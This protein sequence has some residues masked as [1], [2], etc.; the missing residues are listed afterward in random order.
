MKTSLQL[1]RRVLA[2]L[3]PHRRDFVLALI[4]MV[5]FGASD[6]AVPFLVKHILDDVFQHQDQTL[7][8]LLPLVL[9]VYAV[10]RALFD[11]GQQYLMARIGHRVIRDMRNGL[12][13]HLLKLEPGFFVRHESADLTARMTSDVVLVRSLLTETA[14]AIIRDSIR[15]V[16]LLVA[17][18]YLD[19]VLAVIAFVFFP[20]GIYPVY[21]FGRRMRKLS[22][23]GQEGIGKLSARLQESILG[24]RVVKIFG[25]EKFESERFHTENQALT[26][27]FVRSEKIRAL[28][29]PINEVLATLVISGVILYGGFSVIG[30]VRTQGDFVAFL[31]SV[32]LLYD[33]F[34][35][36]S[37]VHNTVQQGMAG[38]E[39]IFGILDSAPK[40][41]DPAQPMAL[42]GSNTIEFDRVDF[43]YEAERQAVCEIN[44]KIEERT[45][46]ALVGFSG[47]GKSTLAD[48]IPRFIDP[49][50]GAVRIGGIDISRVRLTELRARIAM[51]GQHTFLFND[52]IYNNIAYGCPGVTRE[53]VMAAA[54]AA[55]AHDFIGM[56][57]NGYESIVGEGGFAL[58]GGERQ[59]I[60]I[61]RAILK[62]APILILDE[63]TASLDNRAEREVQ[64]ALD[65][66]ERDR[67]TVVIAHRLSTVRSADLIVVMRDGRIVETGKHQELLH[68]AGEYARLHAMQFEQQSGA[69]DA[70]DEIII[71]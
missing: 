63:A 54:R 67:T 5:L 19:P 27:T 24:N 58:S 44:L 21:R 29:G 2:Y 25:R 51:V 43:S 35:K 62:D 68:R 12:N 56:L 28:T 15:V 70:A 33:P 41:A 37:R 66:L 52:T 3:R 49:Q 42:G 34:K 26:D 46:V 16:A 69:A 65:A 71:N 13:D 40:I 8:Y 61:A 38:V 59:R 22:R 50:K 31:I 7:L 10:L 18:I 39:R 23:V 45:R 11:F 57:P 53:Q 48:L 17:A 55:Y 30:G 32:F 60:A 9:V 64:A 1:Y 6:G 36:L 20:I 4:C 47:S 14:A